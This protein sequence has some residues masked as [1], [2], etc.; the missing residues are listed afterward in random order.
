MRSP[1]TE[2]SPHPGVP[3][4]D[5]IAGTADLRIQRYDRWL[6]VERLQPAWNDLLAVSEART[7]FLTWEW[8]TS[9]W[10]AYGGTAPLM[11]LACLDGTGAA[12]GMAPLFASRPRTSTWAPRVLRVVGD[13]SFD[14]DNLS[15]VVRPTDEAAVIRLWLDWLEGHRAEWDVLEL[16]TM[17]ADSTVATVLLEELRSRGWVRVVETAPHALLPLPDDWS[18][19]LRSLSDNM[20]TAI[21]T[22][23]RRLHRQHRVSLRRVQDAAELP[24]ALAALYELH[25]QRWSVRGTAGA[26]VHPARR[27]FLEDLTRRLLSR[28]WLDF[29]ILEVDGARVATELGFRQGDTEFFFQSG[30]HPD[31]SAKSV[32]L[33]LKA[34][35]LRELIE[36]QVRFYDFLG[37]DEDYKLRWGAERRAYLSVRCAPA[38]SRGGL[39]LR[40]GHLADRTRE[41]LR[42]RIPDRMWAV[43]RRAY[44]RIKPLATPAPG[45]GS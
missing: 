28:G 33:V 30:F 7:V 45:P 11:L 10:K 20:R 21:Q 16:N 37:G 24:S 22:R 2:P 13:G 25:G 6:P 12:V 4:S 15:L 27:V 41:W 38:R 39:H 32:G 42:G 44:R 3:V 8:L 9:W 1:T 43:G 35:I 34:A 40:A 26:F 5:S 29:W 14:S 19:Y 36:R 31:W 23:T 17:P 18:V